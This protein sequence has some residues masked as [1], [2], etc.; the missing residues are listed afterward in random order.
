MT[1]PMLEELDYVPTPMGDL[2]L[3]RRRIAML[4]DLEVVEVK[5]KD[6]YL[7]STLFHEAEVALTT[8][9]LS[10]L[11]GSGWEIVVGGLGLGYTAAA[12]LQWLQVEQMTV[13]EALLPVIDWHQRRLVPNG[14]VLASDPRCCLR[15]GDFFAMARGDGFDPASP[16]RLFD[17]VL[18]DVDHSPS[19]TLSPSHDV[20][21]TE[22]GLRQLSR[23][24][25]PGGYFGLWSNDPPENAFL[26][27]LKTVFSQAEGKLVP[28]ANPLTDGEETNGLYIAKL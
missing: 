13:V 22:E 5:L 14:D 28:F 24:L 12:A 2:I 8:E 18:L 20:F 25:K 1:T 11:S 15:H 6:E 16:N 3:Q 10:R 19:H 27:R 4:N 9:V 23:F 21:Y 17:A 26:D 7:M